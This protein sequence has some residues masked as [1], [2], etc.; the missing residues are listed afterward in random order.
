MFLSYENLLFFTLV[1]HVSFVVDATCI[2]PSAGSVVDS[3][4]DQ[5]NRSFNFV[6]LSENL[7]EIPLDQW[8]KPFTVNALRNEILVQVQIPEVATVCR[9]LFEGVCA[10][11]LHPLNSALST[12]R[13]IIPIR[14]VES[15]TQ[16]SLHGLECLS[17]VLMHHIQISLSHK[18]SK[19]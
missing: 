2:V 5:S 19:K 15:I 6:N 7:T 13:E 3:S 8:C 4:R 12:R 11:F 10:S 18:S 1:A 16:E 14:E 17:L 9:N